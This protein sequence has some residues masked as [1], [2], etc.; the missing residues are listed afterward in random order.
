[1]PSPPAVHAHPCGGGVGGGAGGAG[2]AGAAV[3]VA[4][5]AA[6]VGAGAAVGGAAALDDAA[7]LMRLLELPSW[8]ST[9]GGTFAADA[10][11]GRHQISLHTEAPP[12]RHTIV[13][14]YDASESGQCVWL[15]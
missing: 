2:S 13:K 3:A 10:L 1:V 8:A 9:S 14:P 15:P 5:G 12:L 6:G 7:G 11:A 4:V